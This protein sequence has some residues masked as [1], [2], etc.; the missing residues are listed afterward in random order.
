MASQ[1]ELAL[2][3]RDP[4]RSRPFKNGRIKTA[5][6]FRDLRLYGTVYGMASGTVQTHVQVSTFNITRYEFSNIEVSGCERL[7]AYAAL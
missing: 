5:V 7:Q 3:I 4:H 2:S 6:K 1:L